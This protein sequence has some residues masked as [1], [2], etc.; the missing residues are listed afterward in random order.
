MIDT[1]ISTILIMSIV[2]GAH[3]LLLIAWST[4]INRKF[5]KFQRMNAYTVQVSKAKGDRIG[6][7]LRGNVVEY[8]EED[9]ICAGLIAVKDKLLLVNGRRI[10]EA[11]T[12]SSTFWMLTTRTARAPWSS[13]L[14]D[15]ECCDLIRDAP[16]IYLLVASKSTATTPAPIHFNMR[17]LRHG[18]AFTPKES[19]FNRAGA[20]KSKP[21]SGKRSPEQRPAFSLKTLRLAA[22]V[23]SKRFQTT[24]GLTH[25]DKRPAAVCE[26]ETR[27]SAGQ[28]I[29]RAL[30]PVFALA[31]LS[32]KSATIAP[33]PKC[34]HTKDVS[35]S[36]D[37]L[38]Q[39]TEEVE[40]VLA[41]A[42]GQAA[43]RRQARLSSSNGTEKQASRDL[44][45]DRRD[46]FLR[47]NRGKAADA[48][49]DATI[50]SCH[51]FAPRKAVQS[52]H[53]MPPPSNGGGAELS[54]RHA[55]SSSSDGNTTPVESI[56]RNGTPDDQSFHQTSS[57][58]SRKNTFQQSRLPYVRTR[59]PAPLVNEVFCEPA[60]PVITMVDTEQKPSKEMSDEEDDSQVKRLG[61]SFGRLSGSFGGCS[62]RNLRNSFKRLGEDNA[63]GSFKSISK[64]FQQSRIPFVA[65]RAKTDDFDL[66]E[67][68]GLVADIPTELVDLE[69]KSPPPSPPGGGWNDAVSRAS[70]ESPSPIKPVSRIKGKLD[71]PKQAN[72]VVLRGFRMR[73][74]PPKLRAVYEKARRSKTSRP[75]F[76]SL[77]AA[78]VW[79]GM[80][81]KV[82]AVFATGLQQNACSL[83]G[84]ACAGYV[85]ASAWLVLAVLEVT[86]VTWLYLREGSRLFA[87]LRYHN[88]TCWTPSDPMDIKAEQDDPLLA[89]LTY[90][91]KGLI[92]PRPRERGSFEPP[93]DESVEPGRTE[94][95]LSRFF[96]T[97]SVRRPTL[98]RDLP[99]ADGLAEL[100][101]WLEDAHGS[102]L[103]VFYLF[104][105]TMHQM[106]TA[107]YLGFFYANPWAQG[108]I[109]SL[110]LLVILVLLQIGA[111]FWT[112]GRT[113]NDRLDAM[114]KF[115]GYFLEA[116]A[117][118]LLCASAMVNLRDSRGASDVPADNSLLG[119]NESVSSTPDSE[120][121]TGNDAERL[122]NL[123]ISLE[124]ASAS[125]NV[126]FM[127]VFFP[128]A[129]AVYDSFISPMAQKIWGADGNAREVV[130]QMITS[131]LL[132][133]Y[134]FITSCFASMGFGSVADVVS[135]LE[136][137]AV[138][139][140]A[141]SNELVQNV[142]ED[143]NDGE[144][145]KIPDDIDEDPGSA[146]EDGEIDEP[147]V[148]R[149]PLTTSALKRMK[150]Q[151][152]V[153]RVRA[154]LDA[155][156]TETSSGHG[157]HTCS[158]LDNGNGVVARVAQ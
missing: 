73:S 48:E 151:A 61:G 119:S 41:A 76:T 81:L 58:S 32:R 100:D 97:F 65:R 47:T 125:A 135:E 82:L 34:S 16:K 1:T 39:P 42:F 94:R 96:Q 112:L 20:I 104:A 91:T 10:A 133:P 43:V 134:T 99:A 92:P 155:R 143:E 7:G 128:I 38:R 66:S 62:P 25:E 103:G 31:T 74:M 141:A 87:F 60:L 19:S 27:A 136:G 55:L 140:A 108:S 148:Q 84:A 11:N 126:L 72:A 79:P 95:A 36:P 78:L 59:M 144:D 139:S 129:I 67:L 115:T 13:R 37:S 111:A 45:R 26:E 110:F 132:L 117:C 17:A 68:S 5:Y 14:S 130:C 49:A 120:G 156:R 80:E 153:L 15:E 86:F 23:P 114:G 149:G 157:T 18:L 33:T 102:K 152:Y 121:S 29:S 83:I 54:L 69:P 2:F 51:T 46:D 63:S 70:Q 53:E 24:Q 89:L 131:C 71:T 75:P 93:E 146:E 44:L 113:A 57:G 142:D 124:L 145:E 118:S 52:K 12:W 98:V 154:K 50:Q 109:G 85:V 9:S 137:A 127:A 122:Q 147:L 150:R 4:R 3:G 90:S 158:S 35:A 64:S 107:S 21:E 101:M 105:L 28:R 77:P 22:L 123:T 56:S 6:I 106:I 8:V 116:V 138:D 88:D 30:K 40:G